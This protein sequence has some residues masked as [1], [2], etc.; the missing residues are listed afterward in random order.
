MV[1]LIFVMTGFGSGSTQ[2]RGVIN[3]SVSV[4]VCE[5]VEAGGL[6]TFFGTFDRHTIGVTNR[7]PATNASIPITIFQASGMSPS[8]GADV[9]F[10]VDDVV[11]AVLRVDLVVV[12]LIVGILVVVGEVTECAV[13]VTEAVD[14]VDVD[15]LVEDDVLDVEVEVCRQ[16]VFCAT[17]GQFIITVAVLTEAL[18]PNQNLPPSVCSEFKSCRVM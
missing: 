12:E 15:F 13:V 11:V 5:D 18:K 6:G 16:V 4:V 7:T 8:I 14:V 3:G 1:G 2:R 17:A 9:V 10:T